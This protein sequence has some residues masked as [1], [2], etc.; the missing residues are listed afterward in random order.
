MLILAYFGT[1]LK[2]AAALR[3][4]GHGTC[5]P[6]VCRIMA[7]SLLILYPTSLL[8]K[9]LRGTFAD[10]LMPFVRPSR[11]FRGHLMLHLK[12]VCNKIEGKDLRF[13]SHTYMSFPHNRMRT[14]SGRSRIAETQLC[15][16]VAHLHL[17]Q[18]CFQTSPGKVC[19][20]AGERS[21]GLTG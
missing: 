20:E 18:R 17:P 13:S 5:T 15:E 10:L 7:C 4:I 3:N 8:C 12:T 9:S 16:G 19:G 6:H 11:N 14:P 2:P 21:L 1:S